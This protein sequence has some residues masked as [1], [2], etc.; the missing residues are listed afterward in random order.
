MIWS[1]LPFVLLKLGPINIQNEDVQFMVDDVLKNE[2]YACTGS[3]V[4]ID[5]TGR[6]FSADENLSDDMYSR[7]FNPVDGES[8]FNLSNNCLVTLGDGDVV[9]AL[10]MA[11]QFIPIGH[12]GVVRSHSAHAFGSVGYHQGKNSEGM[13]VNLPP[14]YSVEFHVAVQSAISPDMKLF[15]SAGF[16]IERAKTKKTMGNEI[17][18]WEGI[19]NSHKAIKSCSTA[20]PDAL[21]MKPSSTPRRNTGSP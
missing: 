7:I 15:N 18:K 17:I 6:I 13:L 12:H 21:V 11:V 1:Y 2:D 8:I 16:R 14:N 20:K 3:V 10:E 9:P 4:Q 19:P 5:F